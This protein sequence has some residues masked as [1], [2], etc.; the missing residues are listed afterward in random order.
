MLSEATIPG[1]DQI[2]TLRVAKYVSP[3]PAIV[4]SI[5]LQSI[6]LGFVVVDQ[7][8]SRALVPRILC[9]RLATLLGIAGIFVLS[10]VSGLLALI[11]VVLADALVTR[12]KRARPAVSKTS[13][14]YL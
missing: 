14:I 9:K 7:A 13:Y 2:S 8:P 11:F 6:A 12:P 4:S 5:A 3:P 10:A 1:F